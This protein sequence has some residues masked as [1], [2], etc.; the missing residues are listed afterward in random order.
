M[1][2][3]GM[4]VQDN[5]TIDFSKFNIVGVTPDLLDA[6]WKVRMEIAGDKAPLMNTCFELQ[7]IR[8]KSG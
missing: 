8:V 7:Y 2:V 6:Y 5:V 1:S 4:Y 3:Q